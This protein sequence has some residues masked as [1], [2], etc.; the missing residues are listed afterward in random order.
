MDIYQQAA[1]I[2]SNAKSASVFTGAGV[3]AESGIPTFRDP[4]GIWDRFKPEEVGTVSAIMQI[5]TTKPKL[6]RSFL[7]ETLQVFEKARANDAHFAI[8]ELE[9]LGLIHSVL[10]QNIDSLHSHAGSKNIFEIHGTLFRARCLDCGKKSRLDR[11]QLF[12]RAHDALDD[13]DGFTIEKVLK[14]LPTCECG[15]LM[16]PDVVMFGESVQELHQAFAA[17]AK[18]D[19][20]LVLGT[21][22]TVYPAAACPEEA[23]RQGAKLI[24][25]NPTDNYYRSMTEIHIQ[26]AAAVAMPKIMKHIQK[27]TNSASSQ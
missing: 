6:I 2:L 26:E 17:A 19:V 15:G 13:A 14:V 23:Y 8:A 7:L 11:D 18:S 3:S 16:R 21:T 25:I 12:E 5:A 10:T 1:E 9:K 22:G 24:E 27:P 4:G 20:M